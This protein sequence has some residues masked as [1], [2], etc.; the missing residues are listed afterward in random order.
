MNKHIIYT[1]DA[2]FGNGNLG[3]W[4]LLRLDYFRVTQTQRYICCAIKYG[5][6]ERADFVD[7]DNIYRETIV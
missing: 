5:L 1:G 2:P 7:G 6:L 4:T 3:S